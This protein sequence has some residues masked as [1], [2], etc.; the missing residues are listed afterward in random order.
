[1][2]PVV[3]TTR[4]V[5]LLLLAAVILLA[6]VPP[7]AASHES[8]RTLPLNDPVAVRAAAVVRTDEGLRGTTASVQVTAAQNGSGHIFM[9]T[10][11]LTQV[12]MQGSARM[13]VRVAASITGL[14]RADHDFFFVIRSDSS[15]IGGPSAGAVLT[16][17]SVAAMKGWTVDDD[18]LMTGTVNPDG[19]VGAVG[20]IPEKAR[21]AWEAG[22]RLFLY[23]EGQSNVTTSQGNRVHLPDWC[24]REIGI[25]CQPVGE[26]SEAVR[27]VTGHAFRPTR[28]PGNVTDEA[29]KEQ[30]RPLAHQL[31]DGANATIDEASAAREGTDLPPRLDIRMQDR[32]DE[33]RQ[34]R[35]QAL[36]AWGDEKYYT[37][38]SRSF[39]ATVQARGVLE[40]ARAW[41]ADDA[42]SHI[43]GRFD[44]ADGRIEEVAGK[45]DAA[46]PQGLTQLQAVGAAQSR[47]LEAR[48]QLQE[49]R[50]TYSQGASTDAIV[51][52]MDALAF[53]LERA[54]TVEWWLRIGEGFAGGPTFPDERLGKAAQ[55]VRTSAQ[56]SL[57]YARVLQQRNDGSGTSPTLQ[58]AQELLDSSKRAQER[59]F[60]PAA[61][62][63][64][65]QA[66]VW[67]SVG[68]SG[69]GLPAEELD[70]RVNRSR[71]R[72]AVAIGESR[73]LGVEPILAVAYFEFAGE[74]SN[75]TSQLAFFGFAR[76][77]AQSTGVL[78]DT[79]GEPRAS[80]FVG[81][82]AALT[83]PVVRADD[84]MA[85]FALSLSMG[86]GIA[87][88]ATNPG[89]GGPG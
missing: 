70:E 73:D 27:L 64:A 80:R 12:D 88:A 34:T 18:V 63:D 43:R 60:L 89:R 49:A 33:A 56:E 16:V 3:A 21:A 81:P 2:S 41:A 58:R 6:T 79:G 53:A 24:P 26:V 50:S 32:L 61:I 48:D 28:P 83:S 86:V 62:Y 47:V 69:Q 66:E 23:P 13:A 9:D 82:P 35:R 77:I 54:K 36:Q 44:A 39:Q 11:P 1:M 40:V 75:P 46:D 65:L 25:E 4:R 45:A 85:V 51:D 87:L 10:V 76:T 29:Y 8:G 5:L 14:P 22:G 59:G 19:T 17:A 37:T 57:S 7:S 31:L 20:G 42:Q 67:V 15:I 84:L 71:D 78:L 55:E 72:A 38:A 30:L 74:L 52:A 68:L